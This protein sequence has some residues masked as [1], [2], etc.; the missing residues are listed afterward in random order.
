MVPPTVLPMLPVQTQMVDLHVH[1]TV[2][3]VVM[4]SH[5]P[6]RIIF[7]SLYITLKC[8]LPQINTK[9]SELELTRLILYFLVVTC[10]PV[11]HVEPLCMFM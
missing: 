3:I 11:V 5:V 10:V 4:V 2:D 6:V 7:C 1:A 8:V 9:G